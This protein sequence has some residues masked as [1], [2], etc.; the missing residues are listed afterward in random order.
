MR[1]CEGSKPSR[2]KL[3]LLVNK[4]AVSPTPASARRPANRL[5]GTRRAAGAGGPF[6]PGIAAGSVVG[7]AAAVVASFILLSYP[8][9]TLRTRAKRGRSR[10]TGDFP[11]GE[12]PPKPPGGRK[13]NLAAGLRVTAVYNGG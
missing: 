12:H 9:I 11:P 7:G 10:V 6:S 2:W 13:T 1:S 5:P 3:Q 4:S 8:R